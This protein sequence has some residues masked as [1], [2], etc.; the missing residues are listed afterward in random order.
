MPRERVP[1]VSSFQHWRRQ[2]VAALRAEKSSRLTGDGIAASLL[3]DH[4]LA[5]LFALPI[6]RFGLGP[7]RNYFLY[8]AAVRSRLN[9]HILGGRHFELL[10]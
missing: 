9:R 7:V 1:S 8:H 5:D 10:R 6:R 4:D 3:V 2:R